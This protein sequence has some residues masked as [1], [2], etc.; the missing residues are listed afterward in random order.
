MIRFSFSNRFYYLIGIGFIAFFAFW[1]I[2]T[3][4]LKQ[5][6]IDFALNSVNMT[7]PD[8]LKETTF[9]YIITPD[10][11]MTAAVQ[12]TAKA[13]DSG[14]FLTLKDD[15]IN[16]NFFDTENSLSVS[17]SSQSSSP[18]QPKLLPISTV[19]LKPKSNEG[20]II[21]NNVYVK[22]E[23]SKTIDLKAIMA[24]A[25][26]F[27]ISKA[28]KGPQVLIF[29]T[30]ATEAFNEGG[31]AEYTEGVYPRSDDDSK[32]VA[33]VGETIAKELTANS[34]K[35]VQDKTHHDGP[36]YNGAYTRSLATVNQY[37]KK[38]P[39][40]KIVLD[41]H[42]DS[43]VSNTGEQYRPVANIGGKSAA[44]IMI[45][46]GLGTKAL[47]NSHYKE[48]LK[49]AALLQSDLESKYAGLC[50]PILLRDSRYNEHTAEGA[51][52]IEIGS[53]GNTIEEAQYSGTLLAKSLSGIIKKYAK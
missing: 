14:S 3:G 53:S 23:S 45:L 26:K 41:I 33:A 48:N 11:F 25:L 35:V 10:G 37:L 16:E 43:L 42:R 40:I 17:S 52:L 49:F 34:I 20:Y 50:R 1:L 30:H 7:C 6:A 13:Y 2:R 29:N 32:N 12:T 51:L 31:K 24:E 4:A 9:S 18:N 19:S 28:S 39:T 22:N 8:G 44:Q 46:V 21:N 38:Y 47:P 27:K 15:K 5:A 36:S